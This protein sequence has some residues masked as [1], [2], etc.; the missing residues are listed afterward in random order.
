MSAKKNIDGEVVRLSMGLLLAY[1]RV[2]GAAV[3]YC[4]IAVKAGSRDD[5]PG[6]EGMAHFV[7]HTIFKG[8]ERRTL[9]HINNRMERVGG[10]INAF[11]TKEETVVYTAAPAG[12][13]LR[14]MDL[15]GDLALHSRFP[16]HEIDKEREV[17]ADEINTY[18][19]MPGDAI[20]DDFED[21]I[22]AG[23]SLGHNI[24]G[25]TEALSR[26]NSPECMAYL[27]KWYTAPNITVFYSGPASAERV[28]KAVEKSFSGIS[29]E[30]PRPEGRA[31]ESEAIK[32]A[33]IFDIEK[34]IGSHQA[35]IVMGA[36][37]SG[38]Y[39]PDRYSLSLLT[40]MLGGPGMNSILNV[41]LREK[42]GLVYSVEA[43]ASFLSDCG[44][45]TVYF[46]CDPEDAGKCREL[47]ERNISEM[48]A[49]PLSAMALAQ[50]KKQFLGQLAVASD[51]RENAAISD[52]RAALWHGT[53]PDRRQVAE[54]INAVTV[55]EL[56]ALAEKISLLSTLT[57]R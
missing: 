35:H 46:G 13:L 14:A 47:V 4:G 49:K 11:T 2:P 31:D 43:N 19:D 15:I 38:R 40:N 25:N 32:G 53:M 24:L 22:F 44:L 30:N 1:R 39:S 29:L 52:G 27:R 21:L 5:A 45:F 34:Q 10:E 6:Q 7:E 12:N 33:G 50:A 20:F 23:T 28:A 17:V 3:E 42:R 55:E 8:T 56:R 9:W 36:V 57:F 41:Q 18:L 51:N 54:R 16:Q 26:F 48:A 37:A